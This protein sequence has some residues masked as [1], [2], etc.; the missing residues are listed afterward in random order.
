MLGRR[1]AGLLQGPS[2]VWAELEILTNDEFSEEKPPDAFAMVGWFSRRAGSVRALQMTGN[3]PKL[4]AT[5]LTAVLMSQA[6]SLR[7]LELDVDAVKLSGADLAV[8][9]ALT[10]LESLTIRPPEEADPVAGWDDHAA[11]AIA[12]VS[13]L[14]A[15]KELDFSCAW[16]GSFKTMPTADQLAA[17]QSRSLTSVILSMSSSRDGTLLLGALPAL[18]SC[19]LDLAARE[20]HVLHVTA[21]SF[22]GAPGLTNLDVSA[23]IQ[24][25]PRCF[26]GLSRLDELYLHGCELKSV[27]VGLSVLG[28]T[29]RRLA[30]T[31]NPDMHMPPHCLNGLSMLTQL[32][33]RYCELARV[34]ADALSGVQR[35]LRQLDLSCNPGM[36]IGSSSFSGLAVLE[37]ITIRYCELKQVPM[38]LSAVQRTLRRLDLGGNDDLQINQAG[39]DTLLPMPVLDWLDLTSTT[40]KYNGR[41][42]VASTRFLVRFLVEWQQLHPGAQLPAL[43]I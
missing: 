7:H 42:S 14:P 6:A 19:M 1:W 41:R 5:L 2:P 9:V 4:P 33:L 27:P 31:K 39:F 11:A 25:A 35:S 23:E 38:A 10:G 17:L 18:E 8:L 34:P 16:N 20:G 26:S 36:C 22:R 24:L 30:F 40:G 28:R 21:E 15:P 3:W 13:Q 37:D 12:A 32:K 29:L 43:R